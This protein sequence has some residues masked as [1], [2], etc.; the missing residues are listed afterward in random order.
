MN[1]AFIPLLC[2]AALFA[3]ET[4]PAKAIPASVSKETLLK[5]HD[6][7][8][9]NS[10]TTLSASGLYWQP[11]VEGLDYVL[12]NSEG[13]LLP[14]GATVKH[15]DFD[16]SG[17]FRVSAG[18]KLPEQMD[19]DFT[20]T[21]YRSTGSSSQNDVS[22]FSTLY[23]VW[24]FPGQTS[25]EEHGKIS[26]SLLLNLLDLQMS[27]LFSPRDFFDLKT[28]FSLIGASLHQKYNI[29]LSGGTVPQSQN[30][31]I[32]DDHIS[33][34]NKFSGIGPKLGLDTIWILGK[35]LSI[36][37][38]GNLAL[39]YGRFKVSQAE[40]ILTA[41][42]VSTEV[43]DVKNHFTLAR[44]FFDYVVGVRWDYLFT[45]EKCRFTLEAGWEN[46]L[47]FGQ[48]NLIR[49]PSIGQGQSGINIPGKGDLSL[50]GLTLKTGFSF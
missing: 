36:F 7:P 39:L 11:H 33:M 42:G 50:Q 22:G 8:N 18:G 6:L 28:S 43:V 16:W 3:H 9:Q 17:G 48:N 25:S 14:N 46:L 31:P 30:S 12:K 49:F 27:A 23:S 34:K 24:S 37:G 2:T 29:H 45:N 19:L 13:T 47:F 35:G 38:S 15:M 20:W 32:V 26:G 21:C 5:G 40:S 1:Y 4:T 10:W 44:A 41:G